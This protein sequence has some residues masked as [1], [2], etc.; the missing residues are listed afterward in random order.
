MKFSMKD[1]FSKCD[2]LLKKTLMEN[3]IFC[4]VLYLQVYL[5]KWARSFFNHSY[6]ILVQA[7]IHTT[8][9]RRE[10]YTKN[11]IFH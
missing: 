9:Q 2:H 3:I 8:I 1:F 10:H 6:F 5:K 11:E 4:A 7:F